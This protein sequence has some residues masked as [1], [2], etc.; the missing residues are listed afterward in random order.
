MSMRPSRTRGWWKTCDCSAAYGAGRFGASPS[1]E[2]LQGS[3]EV[4]GR[5]DVTGSNNIEL[6]RYPVLP[7][8]PG[9]E[10]FHGSVRGVT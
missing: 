1:A 8:D 7:I 6:L 5:F 4:W 3:L 2:R 9:T 10:P